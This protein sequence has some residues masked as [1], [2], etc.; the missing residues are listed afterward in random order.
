MQWSWDQRIYEPINWSDVLG[1]C[2]IEGVF[3]QDVYVSYDGSTMLERVT[4]NSPDT[5]TLVGESVVMTK[6]LPVTDL[7]SYAKAYDEV[8]VLREKTKYPVKLLTIFHPEKAMSGFYKGVK[9][10]HKING[11]DYKEVDADIGPDYVQAMAAAELLNIHH[12]LDSLA[13]IEFD[14]FAKSMTTYTERESK[15]EMFGGIVKAFLGGGTSN[16][17]P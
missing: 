15:K 7:P 11:R 17:V 5:G 10:I 3:N 13:M 2:Q 4:L 9:E 6:S 1:M 8:A 12:T 16:H 14:L